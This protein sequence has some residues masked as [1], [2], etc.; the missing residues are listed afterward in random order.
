M[1]LQ[2][3]CGAKYSFDITPEMAR[4]PIRFVCQ[5]CGYDSSD[6]VNE[7]IRKKLAEQQQSSV[8][9]T[10]AA[11]QPTVVQP[12]APAIVE[13]ELPPSRL[14]VA[15]AQPEPT[16]PVAEATTTSTAT[17]RPKPCAKHPTQTAHE[18]CV[19]CGK[20]I[21]PSC[22]ELF[23]YVCSPL[24]KAR[25]DSHGIEIPFYENQKSVREAKQWRKLA[26]GGGAIGIVIA[27]LVG[28]W[29]WYEWFG[30]RPKPVFS[31]HFQD[32]VHSGASRLCPSDQLVFLRGGTLARYDI[33]AQKEIW[34]R[35]L[36]DRKKIE[37]EVDAELKAFQD[38]KNKSESDDSGYF[39]MP[40][41]EKLIELAFR[42]AAETLE[43][44][45][46][47]SNVWVISP[48]KLTHFAWD[49]GKTQQE[50]PRASGFDRSSSRG[51]ELTFT[52]QDNS[53][54]PTVTH[55]NLA[56]GDTTKE[57]ITGPVRAD[58]V[59]A[60]PPPTVGGL[61]TGKPG[62]GGKPLDP[63]K[64]ASQAQS[65]SLPAKIALP[66]TLASAMHN[67]Q[68][69]AALS[70]AGKTKLQ[71]LFGVDTDDRFQF[72]PSKN[73]NV[74]FSV[75]LLEK[76]IVAHDAMKAA[77]K[78]SALN[79]EVNASKT[80]EVANEILNEMQRNA[81]GNWVEE[82]ESRYQITVHLP[83]A[84]GGTDWTQEITG[85][86]A[87]FV[88]KTVNVIA[89]NKT[90]VV[91][92]KS[93]KKLWQAALTYN[94]KGR[95]GDEDE[96]QSLY[97]AGPFVERGDTLYVADEAVLTAFDLS[98]GNARWRLPSVG[99]VGM[100]FDDK[101]MIYV[102]TTTASPDK[103]RYSRQID[104]TDNTRSA[105]VKL[106]PKTGKTL[107][108]SSE[109]GF[110]THMSG[111]FIYTVAMFDPG[112]EDEENDNDLTAILRRPAYLRIRRINSSNGK[113]MWEHFQKRAPLNVQFDQ[114]SIELVFKNEVQVLRF[115]SL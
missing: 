100:F 56:T 32:K 75:K 14:R 21:C 77:P 114:N 67:Q 18:K 63:A 9:S 72:I 2:C 41:R 68:I 107:W 20:P 43:L 113:L 110:I 80:S 16:A 53:G 45:A 78:N 23:G 39:K 71:K 19:V 105:I 65:L 88:L 76:K 7:M 37:K 12:P 108:S 34:S 3:Q 112:D 93:D 87:V 40:S 83:D 15:H 103:I 89:A 13:T 61:P 25:A 52:G 28:A 86:P 55:V 47:G 4:Q 66:A 54:N 36:I 57:K 102:N 31:V 26:I 62:A 115:L 85:R 42:D 51:D 50:I 30:S 94:V 10:P 101:G 104:V 97:G 70:D 22:M 98:T 60:A 111:K 59:A 84:S 69:D 35:E 29:I 44:K 82:D 90:V 38:A 1:K 73:G 79:G 6:F 33:K 46:S 64:I 109:H 58:A 49:D 8:T 81:G 27:G 106:D 24:C 17:A 74:E 5:S 11:F 96:Q 99:V 95:S 92:D 48:E 91:L